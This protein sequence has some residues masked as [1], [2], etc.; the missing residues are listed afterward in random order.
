M[1]ILSDIQNAIKNLKGTSLAEAKPLSILIQGLTSIYAVMCDN[2]AHQDEIFAMQKLIHDVVE[3][4]PNESVANQFN[5]LIQNE[6]YTC[7]RE[8][9]L[10]M[11]I[12]IKWW[13]KKSPSSYAI[14]DNAFAST[15]EKNNEIT[16]DHLITSG[17]LPPRINAKKENSTS[18]FSK[19]SGNI[20]INLYNNAYSNE[21]RT[22]GAFA[23]II[24]AMGNAEN[25][26]LITGWAIDLH[27]NL[28][29]GNGDESF[30]LG[31]HLF[32]SL[33]NNQELDVFIMPWAQSEL[34]GK[35]I[36]QDVQAMKKF[37]QKNKNNFIRTLR[38]GGFAKELAQSLYDSA[39][40]RIHIKQT[41]NVDISHSDH[42]KMVVV[43]NR[44]FIG[45]LD[46]SEGRADTAKHHIK[47]RQ[48]WHDCHMQVTGPIVAD[49]AKLFASRWYASS[50]DNIM[51]I[52]SK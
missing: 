40:T 10:I 46:L 51:P 33:I 1:S 4:N 48:N 25:H 31:N 34:A 11:N 24:R 17:I 45:G 2:Y 18:M 42:Q 3:F 39:I 9:R 14:M 22:E 7:L 26:I 32:W 52:Q 37:F 47:H 23:D 38:S 19:H 20:I 29:Y 5:D 21:E 13:N 8:N 43:D 44:L 15:I 35:K 49:A 50:N 30:N 6:Q 27:E 16:I 41:V 28:D 36:Y 12:I